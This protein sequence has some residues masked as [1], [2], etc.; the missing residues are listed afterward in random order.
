MT[1]IRWEEV[2]KIYN[3]FFLSLNGYGKKIH[4]PD[5]YEI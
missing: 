1:I 3:L 4:P 2:T 5:F